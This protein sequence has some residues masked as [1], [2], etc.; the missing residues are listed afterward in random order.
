VAL[1]PPWVSAYVVAVRFP[2]P[3]LLLVLEGDAAHPLRALPEIEVW[4][5][6]AQRAAML[7]MQRLA[8]VFEYH[9]RLMAGQV[10]EGEVRRVAPVRVDGGELGSCLDA[11]EQRVDPHAGPRGFELGPLPPPL[12]AL[13]Q[14]LLPH[15]PA[16]L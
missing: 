11:F 8:V 3:R 13:P 5:E 1:F 6:Q 4:H 7:G 16:F 9:P 14:P 12:D 10:V 2:Q 15:A